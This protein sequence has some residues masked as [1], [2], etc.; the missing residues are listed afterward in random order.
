MSTA[1]IQLEPHLEETLHGRRF[2]GIA[3][4]YAKA[5]VERL[6]GSVHIEYTLAKMGARRLWELLHTE[7]F[8][9]ALRALTGNPAAKMGRAGLN[10]IYLSGTQAPTGRNKSGQEAPSHAA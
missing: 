2:E 9:A 6:R 7:P 10:A 4:P 3:R 1:V 8:V 5:D